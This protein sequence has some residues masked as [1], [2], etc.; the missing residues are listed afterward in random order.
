MM[1]SMSTPANPFKSFWL[2]IPVK[3]RPA[4]ARRCKSTANHLNNVAYGKQAGEILAL[5][6]ERETDGKVPL[7][8]IRP[9]LATALEKSGYRK[10]K[11]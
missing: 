8:V 9:D 2:S 10:C 11:A 7:K 6:I 5:S 3:G 1:R 4:F